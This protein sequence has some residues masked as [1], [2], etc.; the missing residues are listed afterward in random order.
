MLLLNGILMMGVTIMKIAIYDSNS[1]DCQDLCHSI[2]EFCDQICLMVSIDTFNEINC[3]YDKVKQ[4]IQGYHIYF[5]NI[6]KNDPSSLKLIKEMK[7]SSPNC[8]IIMTSQVKEYAV[9]GF[10][11]QVS[12][13]LLKPIQHKQIRR[14]LYR[15]FNELKEEFRSIEVI[16]KRVSMRIFLK[17]I[18][19]VEIYGRTCEICTTQGIITTN[20]SMNKMEQLLDCPCFLRC[21]RSYMINMNYIH[22][23]EQSKIYL[24]SFTSIPLSQRHQTQIKE[25]Y[26]KYILEAS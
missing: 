9:D 5:I 19:Y 21:H 7:Q 3:L 20:I 2:Q 1:I 11:Y 15:C 8:Q 26:H 13:Y 24:D 18:Q 23:I 6:Q 14:S 4:D 16:S 22:K 25:A 10:F 12:D 17:D